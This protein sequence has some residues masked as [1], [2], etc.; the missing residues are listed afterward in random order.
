MVSG[1]SLLHITGELTLKYA[2]LV[3][4]VGLVASAGKASAAIP[5]ATGVFHGCYNVL[6]GSTRLI[7]G[8]NC[9]FLERH[10]A[11]QQ[12]G[13]AGPQGPQGPAG[14]P[15]TNAKIIVGFDEFLG[16]LNIPHAPNTQAVTFATSKAFTA[17]ANGTCNIGLTGWVSDEN[18]PHVE[19]YPSV[20]INTANW[21][22]LGA[23]AELN[24]MGGKIMQG[25]T[26]LGQPIYAGE[27]YTFGVTFKI[28][29]DPISALALAKATITWTCAYE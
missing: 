5:D 6:T 19:M 29:D 26:V 7:D 1:S 3:V 24:S 10:V 13:I 25:S 22:Y 14:P 17:T 11:W 15:G 12:T 16:G 21:T 23:R 2:W 27:K 20:L 18:L 9:S 8:T 28:Y 4:C